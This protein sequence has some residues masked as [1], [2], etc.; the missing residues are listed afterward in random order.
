[1][2]DA[3]LCAGEILTYVFTKQIRNVG[4]HSRYID[5][6][7]LEP[8]FELDELCAP[9]V[10][11]RRYVESTGDA[12]LARQPVVR[13][14]LAAILLRLES[15]KHPREALYETFLQPTDDLR[16]HA[17]LTYD[18]ALVC[19]ALRAL[20]DFLDPART[21]GAGRR[22]A[23]GRLPALRKGAGRQAIFRLVG[24]S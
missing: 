9:V 4:L 21:G 14:G 6:T 3:R 10:A 1:M 2:A 7:L 17:Y 15:K 22:D 13:D 18:N 23:R 5:G 11:L 24:G 8:G 12:S 20:A 19:F 16:N